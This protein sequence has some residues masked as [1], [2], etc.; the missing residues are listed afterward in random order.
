M[1]RYALPISKQKRPSRAS[2]NVNNEPPTRRKCPW[3]PKLTFLMKMSNHYWHFLAQWR[4]ETCQGGFQWV[5]L[6]LHLNQGRH[7]GRDR[8]AQTVSLQKCQLGW[9]IQA[10]GLR[11]EWKRERGEKGPTFVGVL[12]PLN[13]PSMQCQSYFPLQMYLARLK[14]WQ[15]WT[16]LHC[17]VAQKQG[18]ANDSP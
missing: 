18:K 15:K 3:E 17:K 16:I 7:G 2:V 10:E 8:R 5:Q 12:F 9:R 11:E 6:T 4:C 1:I 14:I 13:R